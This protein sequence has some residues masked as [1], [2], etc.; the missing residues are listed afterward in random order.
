MQKVILLAAGLG[1][2][3]A[4]LATVRLLGLGEFEPVVSE[5]RAKE[6]LAKVGF[7]LQTAA[8]HQLPQGMSGLR[9]APGPKQPLDWVGD[10][11][12]DR[13][14][15]SRGGDLLHCI[16]GKGVLYFVDTG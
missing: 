9:I 12:G 1:E 6:A 15:Q 14:S 4:L 13:V 11:V 5:G 10:W 2:A 7:V 16:G 3:I 8:F